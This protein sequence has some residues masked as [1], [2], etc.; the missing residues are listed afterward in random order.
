MLL[1][2]NPART[3]INISA[4]FVVRASKIENIVGIKDSSGDFTLTAEYI[5]RTDESFSVLAG[6]D[7]LIYGTLCYGGKGAIA[8]TANVAPK[9]IVEIYE[10]FMAGDMKRS[11]A[12]QFRLAPLRLAFELGTFPVVIKEA[13]NLI[14]IEAGAAI[15][16]V[17]GIKPEAREEL[18]K[19]LKE[20]E[21]YCKCLPLTLPTLHQR[22]EGW[23]EGG[24]WNWCLEFVWDCD[25]GIWN[26]NA[27]TL[28]MR[29]FKIY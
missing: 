9:V 5:R 27:H 6:R 22:G 26:L 4:N 10:A 3:G 7:T 19:I 24:I 21:R 13:L 18:K 17:G 14:G 2:N 23:G 8:A 1:Y 29:H 11:L 28:E 15:A 12:A 25:L 16:P 20:M